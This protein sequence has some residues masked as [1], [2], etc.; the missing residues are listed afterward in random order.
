[1]TKADSLLLDCLAAK[2]AVFEP[3]RPPF[4][5]AIGPIWV[6]ARWY[7]QRGLPWTGDR[8]TLKELI[9]NRLIVQHRSRRVAAV[10]LTGAGTVEALRLLGIGRPDVLTALS[11]VNK[12]IGNN[13]WVPEALLTDERSSD[14]LWRL[15]LRLAPAVSL[16]WA[17]IHC[18]A[19]G[20][21]SYRST[22]AGRAELRKPASGAGQVPKPTAEITYAFESSYARWHR[23]LNGAAPC[24]DMPIRASVWGSLPE[25]L[26]L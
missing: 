1:M 14:G 19:E 22:K 23:W 21:V 4:T 15:W 8:E 16:G 6:I 10:S 20:H 18:D 3:R 11:E 12:H 9:S 26:T 7:A 24:K 2:M 17:E 13:Y 25:R 5:R